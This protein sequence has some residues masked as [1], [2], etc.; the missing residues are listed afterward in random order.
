MNPNIPL[1][2][3]GCGATLLLESLFVDDGC[4]CNTPRGVNFNPQACATCKVKDCVKPG[5]RLV[6]L[7]GEGA[8]H[9]PQVARLR[10]IEKVARMVRDDL[11]R[12]AGLVSVVLEAELDD[13]LL[14]DDAA[15]VEDC[16]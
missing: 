7:F 13:A 10:E 2:C 4:P 14:P 5:H 11:K 1:K 3:N 8:T 9:A 16:G 15:G 12:C 6:Q